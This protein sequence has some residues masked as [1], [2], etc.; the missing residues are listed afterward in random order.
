[1]QE[2]PAMK[3]D[4]FFVNRLLHCKMQ[5]DWINPCISISQIPYPGLKVN[6]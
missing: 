5:S 2:S 4:W 1:M 3:P 6:L